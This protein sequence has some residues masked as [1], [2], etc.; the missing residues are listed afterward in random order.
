MVRYLSAQR[1]LPFRSET[2]TYYTYF[3]NTFLISD[4][5]YETRHVLLNLTTPIVKAEIPRTYF[6][7][8]D[9]DLELSYRQALNALLSNH[10]DSP[11]TPGIAPIFGSNS[12]FA[13]TQ[14]LTSHGLQQFDLSRM[15]NLTLSPSNL[16]HFQNM[17]AANQ[18][19]NPKYLAPTPITTYPPSRTS[20]S[21]GTNSNTSGYH[22]FNSSTNSLEQLYVPYQPNAQSTSTS[23]SNFSPENQSYGSGNSQRRLS[24][25][26]GNQSFEGS[27]NGI[28]VSIR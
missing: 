27:Y 23:I 26:S 7:P 21:P 1:L 28:S 14:K 22:S 17:V 9:E 12:P 24:E 20:A 13:Q 3:T 19:F 25:S 8:K 2:K 15:Q 6:A 5:I 10:P 18:N 11:L 16:N 4:K